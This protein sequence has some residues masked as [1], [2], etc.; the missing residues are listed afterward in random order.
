MG[1]ITRPCLVTAPELSTQYSK[2]QADF[3]II[4]TFLC[5]RGT[6]MNIVEDSSS[7]NVVCQY[8]RDQ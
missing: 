6:N 5:V 4:H 7:V 2:L 3:Y 8:F 1:Y